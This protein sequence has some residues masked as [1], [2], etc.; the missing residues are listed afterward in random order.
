M[1]MKKLALSLTLAGLCFSQASAQGIPRYPTGAEPAARH[2]GDAARHVGDA[3]QTH[4]APRP[5]GS[6]SRG[7]GDA[8]QQIGDSSPSDSNRYVGLQDD[9]RPEA[10]Q[11]A[12]SLSDDSSALGYSIIAPT[13]SSSRAMRSRAPSVPSAALGDYWFSAETLLWFSQNP[14]SPPLVTTSAPGVLPLAGAAGVTTEFGGGDGIDFGLLPGYRLSAGTYFGDCNKFGIGGRGYGIYSASE[15]YANA[16]NATGGADNPSIGV[17]YYN[18]LATNDFAYL[19]AFENSTPATEWEGTVE[20]RSDLDMVGAD[21]SLYV[22]L[23]R[24]DD[25]RIDLLAGYTFNQLKNS[26]SL[27][28]VAVNRL[29]GDLIPDGTIFTTNDV[30]ETKNTFNGA[31]LGVLS[32]IVRQRVSLS[33]LAK[34]SFGNMRQS[35]AIRGYR[36]EELGGVQTPS[37]GGIFAEPSNIGEFSRDTFAFIPELG[38]KLGLAATD[39]LQFSVGYT[40]M[41]WSGVGL[42]GDQM[43]S[44]IDPSQFIGAPGNRPAH[45]FQETSFWMQGLDLGATFTF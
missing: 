7:I 38:L 20:A 36:V 34:V 13:A 28:T 3:S 2:I 22:L 4:G 44:T 41:M 5:I 42:A 43:D 18:L 14:S 40:F 35:S 37:A 27:E 45:T 32:S 33:T 30:F 31:H 9:A 12:S 21:A 10:F 17:P 25:H 15:G 29:T 6:G 39:N 1:K 19:V 23:G 16:S 26:V 8:S 11:S 24:S